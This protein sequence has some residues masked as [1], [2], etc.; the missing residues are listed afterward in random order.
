MSDTLWKR[1][2]QTEGKHLILKHYLDG[3]FPI[4]GY[5][6]GRLLFIDGFAGPGKYEHGELGSPLIALECVKRH[7]DADRLRQ[8]E[9]VC[10]FIESDKERA[11][12]LEYLL[13]HQTLPPGTIC[14]VL[15]GTFDDHMTGIL[16]YLDEQKAQLAPA[17]VMIDPFGVKGSP[18]NVIERI[19]GNEKSECMIS[20]M[21]EPIRRFHQQSEFEPHLD[22][23]FGTPEWKRCLDMEESDGK[24]RF[25]HDLFSTQLKAN[26]A[27]YVVSFELWRR[28]RHIYTLYFTSGSLKGCDLMKQAIWKVAPYGNYAFY[29]HAGQLRLLFQANTEP[30]A[31]QLR[32]R[33]GD[34]ATPIEEIEE[35]VMSDETIFHSGHLRQKTLQRLEKAGR[36]MVRRPGNARRF[37]SG[38]GI[39]IR[40]L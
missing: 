10:F 2:E 40:F 35:F 39:T 11:R 12:H 26:G 6:N 19:L 17:F 3:W 14:Q 22:N 33:F 18:M 4:L 36:I 32:D 20:F 9:I 8:V 16:D 37:K 23:L 28:N 31:K 5:S 7:K 30:L 27:K 24:K 29:G 34:Y 38:K 25:L 15:P 1:D 21:Y 13:A